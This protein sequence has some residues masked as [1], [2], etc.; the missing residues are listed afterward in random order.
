MRSLV[1]SHF[2]KK[3]IFLK[4]NNKSTHS[5]WELL[6]VLL[7]SSCRAS[8]EVIGWQLS[9]RRGD[10]DLGCS[11][12]GRPWTLFQIS[13]QALSKLSWGVLWWIQICLGNGPRGKGPLGLI[14]EHWILLLLVSISL[15]T[16]RSR[17]NFF[18]KIG[19]WA[20]NFFCCVYMFVNTVCLF[21]DGLEW[22]A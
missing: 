7:L 9:C 10:E 17:K 20:I 4:E 16:S 8:E 19:E 1:Y 15:W 12:S 22:N 5:F 3:S 14:A 21:L 2:I 18:Y 11:S 6:C 13:W